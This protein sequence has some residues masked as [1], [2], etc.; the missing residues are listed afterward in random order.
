[1]NDIVYIFDR[2]IRLS[3]IAMIGDAYL[4][5]E[6][7]KNS[8]W[9]NWYVGFEIVIKLVGPY[10]Y[11]RPVNYDQ[12]MYHAADDGYHRLVLINT[13]DQSI[14]HSLLTI[15]PIG[16]GNYKEVRQTFSP[17]TVD[18]L[19]EGFKPV[20]IYKLQQEVDEL[21]KMWKQ[22]LGVSPFEQIRGGSP[23]SFNSW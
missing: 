1:M 4:F 12:E 9:A 14:H 3:D 16:G 23:K 13:N 22:Q 8:V 5:E 2:H 11:K 17:Y 10:I 15:K 21:V 6:E 20:V 7:G 18:E 19:P